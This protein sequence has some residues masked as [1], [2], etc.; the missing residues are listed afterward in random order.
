MMVVFALTIVLMMFMTACSNKKPIEANMYREKLEKM[1]YQVVDIT[2]Q[3]HN[4]EPSILKVLGNESNG[5]HME[6]FE[7]DTMDHATGLFNVNKQKVESYKGS[8]SATTSVSIGDYR[9]YTL[10]TAEK[11][12]AIVQIGKTLIYSYCDKSNSEK[13]DAIL[14]DLDY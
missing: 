9:K 5:L 11:Y 4:K 8:V 1:G 14:K 12:Y 13:L 3:Y 7:I 2:D 10:K 6:F